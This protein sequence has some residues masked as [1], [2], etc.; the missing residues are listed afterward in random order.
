MSLEHPPKNRRGAVLVFAALLMVVIFAM[1]AMAIDVGYMMLMRTQ[2]QVAADAGALAAGNS[3]HLG[4]GAVISTGQDYATRQMAG[5]RRLQNSEVTVELGTWDSTTNRFTVVNN[6]GNAVRVT[7]RKQR[8]GLFFA[9][10]M[11]PRTFDASASAIAMANPKDIAFVVDL[12]GSMNDDTEPAW[13]TSTVNATFGSQGYPGIGNELMQDVYSDFGFGSFPGV[14]EYIGA[15]LGVPQGELAY[16][17]MTK[18][19]GPLAG[20]AIPATYRIL[21]TDDEATRKRKAYSWMI[22][23]QIAR[24]MP[25]ARP[26]ASSTSNYAY[27]EKYLDYILVS[28]YVMPPPPPSP[29]SPDPEPTPDPGPDPGPAPDPGP[30]PP[31]PP[32]PPPSPPPLG[33]WPSGSQRVH[34]SQLTSW[35]ASPRSLLFGALAAQATYDPGMPPLERGWIPYDQDGD[36][37]YQFNNPNPSSFPNADGGLPYQLLNWIGYVTYTQF[38]MDHGRELQPD[39]AN[40]TPG[41][42]S[43]PS[44]PLHSESTPAG[45]FNFPPRSQPMHATRR[46]II[47][48]VDVLDDINSSIPN[49]GMRDQVSVI[50]FDTQAGSTVR[51]PLTS[52]YRTVMDSVT[53]MQETGDKGATTATESG[54]I[55]AAQHLKPTN[56]GGAARQGT[57]KVVVLLTD[58]MPNVHQSSAGA[59]DSYMRASSNIDY[60]GGG[61]YWIDAPIM[62]AEKMRADKVQIYAVGVGLGTDYDFMDRVART[63]GTGQAARSS[64][65]PAEYEQKMTEIFKKIITT[66]TARLVQ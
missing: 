21:P 40:Y 64:G 32:P 61:Y 24:I 49:S 3:L 39:G 54:M 63:G 27:W 19:T 46:S 2:L 15:P 34:P 31:P 28:A 11:G 47:A 1:A 25:A 42:L 58:G 17:E 56:Q 35:F 5:G 6:K 45:N 37:I 9:K 14:L 26:A 22:D 62:Q 60:K 33:S 44:C 43:N 57:Q 51:Q 41:S 20:A 36:R 52:K 66:P 10:V 55:L 23:F 29:P 7:C 30:P 8:E 18:D 53:R 59:I 38:M 12:S 16:A 50:T 4:R 13:A 65:N 48:A